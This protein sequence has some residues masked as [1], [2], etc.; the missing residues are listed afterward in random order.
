MNTLL[1]ILFALLFF[2][3]LFF[4]VA[5]VRYLRADDSAMDENP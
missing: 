3:G 2:Y 1:H 5:F 4:F